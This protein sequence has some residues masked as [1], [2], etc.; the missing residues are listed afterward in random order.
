MAKKIKES[1]G[2]IVNWGRKN[3]KMVFFVRYKDVFSSTP[4]NPEDIK[5]FLIGKAREINKV[6]NN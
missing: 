1:E 4:V 5:D 2:F 6:K 3:N